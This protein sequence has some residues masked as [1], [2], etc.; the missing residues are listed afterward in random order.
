MV[1]PVPELNILRFV[2]HAVRE[3]LS[4]RLLN[5]NPALKQQYPQHMEGISENQAG[6]NIVYTNGQILAFVGRY[7]PRQHYSGFL[8]LLEQVLNQPNEKSTLY[9]TFLLNH[10]KTAPEW[11]HDDN[12]V[13]LNALFRHFDG[14]QFDT[15]QQHLL[16][17]RDNV[18]QPDTAAQSPLV[19]SL[20]Q[21]AQQALTEQQ[22]LDSAGIPASMAGTTR[23]DVALYIALDYLAYSRL[24]ADT[25]TPVQNNPATAFVA[26]FIQSFVKQGATAL[27]A[28]PQIEAE[29]FAQYFYERMDDVRFHGY[30][31]ETHTDELAQLLGELKFAHAHT[32]TAP[33]DLMR[34]YADFV[35][36]H[37]RAAAVYLSVM[38]D[39]VRETSATNTSALQA[40]QAKAAW[41]RYEKQAQYAEQLH[42]I[43]VDEND[44]T[45]PWDE[46]AQTH[47]Y[48]EQETVKLCFGENKP[49]QVDAEHFAALLSSAPMVQT[50]RQLCH[51]TPDAPQHPYP[52]AQD[53]RSVLYAVLDRAEAAAQAVWAGR[54]QEWED[55]IQVHIAGIQHFLR[56]LRLSG[57]DSNG[58]DPLE[59]DY[60]VQENRQIQNWQPAVSAFEEPAD[61]PFKPSFVPYEQQLRYLHQQETAERS[62]ARFAEKRA[63]YLENIDTTQFLTQEQPSTVVSADPPLTERGAENNV[64]PLPQVTDADFLE[65][66]NGETAYWNDDVAA[67]LSDLDAAESAAEDAMLAQLEAMEAAIAAQDT[68]PAPT[69]QP[70][71]QEAFMP[72]PQPVGAFGTPAVEPTLPPESEGRTQSVPDTPLVQEPQHAPPPIETPPMAATPPKYT[73]PQLFVVMSDDTDGP[74][75]SVR[76]VPSNDTLPTIN[77]D[78]A[79]T[80]AAIMPRVQTLYAMLESPPH[81]YSLADLKRLTHPLKGDCAT[82][83]WTALALAYWLCDRLISNLSAIR[84]KDYQYLDE[85]EHAL[86]QEVSRYIHQNMTS[87]HYPFAAGGTSVLVWNMP[88]FEW[89]RR[90]RVFWENRVDILNDVQLQLYTSDYVRFMDDVEVAL[91]WFEQDIPEEGIEDDWEDW[92]QEQAVQTPAPSLAEATAPIAPPVA[93]AQTAAVLPTP[94]VTVGQDCVWCNGKAVDFEKWNNSLSDL[95]AAQEQLQACLENAYAQNAEGYEFL[96]F[97]P[98]E[99]KIYRNIADTLQ[100]LHFF[101]G[102][103]DVL[104][105]AAIHNCPPI[106]VPTPMVIQINTF[107]QKA[108]AP[109]LERQYAA[110]DETAFSLAAAFVPVAGIVFS[111]WLTSE[112]N[113]RTM[114]VLLEQMTAD[115]K[116]AAVWQNNQATDLLNGINDLGKELLLLKQNVDN[117]HLKVSA[118]ASAS[119]P[120]AAEPDS[121]VL[122]KLD[123]LLTHLQSLAGMCQSIATTSEKGYNYAKSAHSALE[124]WLYSRPERP[125]ARQVAE[126]GQ[127]AADTATKRWFGRGG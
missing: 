76:F 34:Q 104:Q 101:K 126:M 105:V 61:L 124:P 27:S 98:S 52:H 77:N 111:S 112:A 88:F 57:R 38:A 26:D 54:E 122:D 48:D 95:R 97:L 109:L 127:Q 108:I 72:L 123:T 67:H 4:R 125:V 33:L 53:I 71:E 39:A 110:F 121:R 36:D 47:L 32:T 90:A 44:D 86:L 69:E 116:A 20:Y 24:N 64:P 12:A 14:G 79:E 50:F 120:A 43:R 22:Q 65:E 18:S 30:T 6:N 75:P 114:T 91:K 118:Q 19:G 83:N 62:Q 103:G 92:P 106:N 3:T 28:F 37:A 84:P 45:L 11:V 66:L 17:A 5:D 94:A 13:R 113:N 55:G 8:D 93:A 25:D 59:Q 89:L 80:L 60:L 49:P 68:P 7:L 1:S 73:Q 56:T 31:W 23:R 41:G 117:V 96:G 70:A 102:A 81:A 42:Q 16:A 99:E 87:E 35:P 119:T 51:D 63:E 40:Q 15:V 2:L 74:P 78:A 10:L 46:Q 58:L 107:V 21:M 82:L 115:R 9:F 85:Q 100:S 29:K